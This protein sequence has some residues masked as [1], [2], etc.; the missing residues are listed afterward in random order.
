MQTLR[1]EGGGELRR[2]LR[3]MAF[4]REKEGGGTGQGKSF[5]SRVGSSEA[6]MILQSCSQ[7][8]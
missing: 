2:A 4:Q 5:S 1:H 6:G 8:E 3:I 7:L